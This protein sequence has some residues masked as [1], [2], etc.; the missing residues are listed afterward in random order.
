M[1]VRLSSVVLI[2]VL[3][4]SL[5]TWHSVAA[6][7]RSHQEVALVQLEKKW[8]AV[9]DDPDALESILAD[10]FIH[11]LP[12]GFVTKKEQLSYMR[13]H[14]SPKHDTRHFE[15]LRVRVYGSAG[16]AN[17]IVV[18]TDAEGKVRRT[19]FTDVFAYRG[20]RWRAVNAQ[21]LPLSK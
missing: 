3:L 17:G 9:E 2:V 8:L 10:D 20:G 15:D 4:C 5:G 21:E 6:T 19:L 7:S 13:S 11:V 16:V 18:A 1:S 12:A 14:P